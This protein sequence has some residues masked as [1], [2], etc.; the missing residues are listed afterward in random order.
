MIFFGRTT[1]KKLIA[2]AEAAK[3]E[4]KFVQNYNSV[5][6]SYTKNKTVVEAAVSFGQYLASRPSVDPP[7]PGICPVDYRET[8]GGV[9]PEDREP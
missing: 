6:D 4:P 9:R 1:E 2:S 5:F 7:S 8:G 3:N